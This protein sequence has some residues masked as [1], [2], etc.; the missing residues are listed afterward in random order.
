[1]SPTFLKLLSTSDIMFFSP[2]ELSRSTEIITS[3][4]GVILG[5]SPLIASLM[6]LLTL[7]LLVAFAMT[8]LDIKTLKRLSV[9]PFSLYKMRTNEPLTDFFRPAFLKSFLLKRLAGEKDTNLNGDPG[10]SL[11][12]S[13]SNNPPAR[14]RE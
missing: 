12:P 8:L 3:Y 9:K 6:T 14:S 2:R 7:F 11:S 4:P 13:F 5:K 1:M 10:A